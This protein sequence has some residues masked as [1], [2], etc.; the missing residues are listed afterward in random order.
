MYPRHLILVKNDLQIAICPE[1]FDINNLHHAALMDCVEIVE[2]IL[3]T[4]T[5]G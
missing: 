3:E 1:N 2:D 4:L 5:R